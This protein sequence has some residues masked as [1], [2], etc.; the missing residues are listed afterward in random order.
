MKT[1]LWFYKIYDHFRNQCNKDKNY[2]VCSVCGE[3]GHLWKE[4]TTKHKNLISCEG[5]HVTLA[6]KC[7][8]RKKV[9]EEK[10]KAG[11]TKTLNSNITDSQSAATSAPRRHNDQ[12]E[13]RYT[14]QNYTM[15]HL[16]NLS[17]PGTYNIHLN[18]TLKANGLPEF[19]VPCN[20]PSSKILD[21]APN[22]EH[23]MDRGG[24]QRNAREETTQN[25]TEKELEG[26]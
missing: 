13:Q 22:M 3:P 21:K 10:R 9:T 4:C 15:S 6:M 25:E 20:L 12:P 17:E 7:T 19:K 2:K 5:E 11:T 1:C 8:L 14:H 16:C 26:E 23:E 18:E 24:T